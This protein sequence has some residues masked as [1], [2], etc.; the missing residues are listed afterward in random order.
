MTKDPAANNKQRDTLVEHQARRIA[1]ARSA[2]V[3]LAVSFLVLAL[4]GAVIIRL[5][6]Q[7]DFPSLGL[8]VWWALE[9]VTTVGYGDIVPTTEA[10]KVVGGVELI[11]GVSF[12]CFLTAAVT[13]TVI[14]RDETR[15]QDA[16]RAEREDQTQRLLQALNQS[17]VAIAK[18]DRR[19]TSIEAR[20]GGDPPA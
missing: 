12:I 2:T 13:S 5:V 18:L 1:N 4:V 7:H 11:M 3:G 10:G 8:A 20:L 9:T 15:R 16:G 6:D 17:T 19:L 14:Q